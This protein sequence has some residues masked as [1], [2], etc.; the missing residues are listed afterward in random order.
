MITSTKDER[1]RDATQF[2]Q[3][4]RCKTLDLKKKKDGG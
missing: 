3:S 1:S 4:E 2:D